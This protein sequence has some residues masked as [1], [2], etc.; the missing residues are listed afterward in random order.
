MNQDGNVVA[1]RICAMFTWSRIA[2]RNGYLVITIGDAES[3][4]D[5]PA[6]QSISILKRV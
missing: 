3:K 1:V 5:E 2:V 6:P 4:P